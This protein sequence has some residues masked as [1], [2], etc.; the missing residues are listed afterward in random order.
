MA[1]AIVAP[2]VC[3]PVCALFGAPFCRSF[4]LRILPAI[5][6]MIQ[7]AR[8][9]LRPFAAADANEAFACMTPTLTRYMAFEPPA[10]AAVF[11]LIWRQW[12]WKIAEGSDF[13]FTI[14]TL[15]D[16]QF[17]GLAGLHRTAE[18]EPELGIWIRED[19]HGQGYGGE[20]VAAV[21]RWGA[22]RLPVAAF[23]YPVAEENHASRRI[24]QALGGTVFASENTPKYQAVIYRIPRPE[25]RQE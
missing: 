8:L 12:L 24:A 6:I 18:P 5:L 19:A 15:A 9:S 14:R 21:A 25:P 23:I 3:A 2:P 7:T 16:G 17:M 13:V 10:S 1:A 4:L 22:Q 11:E 20:A